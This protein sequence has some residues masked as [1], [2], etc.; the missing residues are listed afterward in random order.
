VTMCTGLTQ[1]YSPAGADSAEDVAC[2]YVGYA[3]GLVRY[4]ATITD[5]P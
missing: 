1:W 3:L 4:R 2:R 5:E